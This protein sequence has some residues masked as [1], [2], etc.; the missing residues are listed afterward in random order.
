MIAIVEAVPYIAFTG[1]GLLLAWVGLDLLRAK[2]R[3]RNVSPAPAES[4]RGL[5]GK[6]E[7][8]SARIPALAAA[9]THEPPVVADAV[10]Q[11]AGESG[12]VIGLRME[13]DS[14]PMP[15]LAPATDPG[16]SFQRDTEVPALTAENVAESDKMQPVGSGVAAA[17]APLV[18]RD[19]SVRVFDTAVAASDRVI[20]AQSG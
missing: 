11:L 3:A 15:A 1:A 4:G 16:L 2:L 17:S 8:L 10:V 7:P 19:P 18:R 20:P 5:A 9:A 14:R 13:A 12:P 6:P